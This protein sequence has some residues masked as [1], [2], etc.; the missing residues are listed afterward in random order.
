MLYAREPLGELSFWYAPLLG[1]R[2][3]TLVFGTRNNLET[4]QQSFGKLTVQSYQMII[5]QQST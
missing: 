2:S 4:T 5:E 3:A 1:K